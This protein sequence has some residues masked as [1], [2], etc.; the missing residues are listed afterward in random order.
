VGVGDCET[1]HPFHRFR[2]FSL[3]QFD[4]AGM[5]TL[6][7]TPEL[8][9]NFLRHVLSVSLH[10]CS[11]NEV[12]FRTHPPVETS[13]SLVP[14]A[15]QDSMGHYTGRF[16]NPSTDLLRALSSHAFHHRVLL[17]IE[18]GRRMLIMPQELNDQ[19]LEFHH[20]VRFQVPEAGLAVQRINQDILLGHATNLVPRYLSASS[21]IF[22]I[23]NQSSWALAKRRKR[24]DESL[25]D[26]FVVRDLED[27]G[28]AG[29]LLSRVWRGPP[30]NILDGVLRRVP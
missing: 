12:K 2:A 1:I 28:E 7:P 18:V 27:E 17:R 19:L 8:P 16:V 30:N 29:E 22:E 23:I 3:R 5:A 25:D 11:M 13:L 21:A 9:I 4:D 26:P 24:K 14:T 10:N 15:D 20:P 6:G